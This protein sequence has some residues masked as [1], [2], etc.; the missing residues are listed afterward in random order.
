MEDIKAKM[1]VSLLREKPRSYLTS[2]YTAASSV[3][4]YVG[5]DI[6]ISSIVTC[7]ERYMKYMATKGNYMIPE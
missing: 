4:Y 5:I 6:P 2:F 3:G 7:V 1:M